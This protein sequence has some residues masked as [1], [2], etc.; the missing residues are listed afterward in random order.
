MSHSHENGGVSHSHDGPAFNAV[1]HGHSHEILGGPGSY[2][3]RE[4]PIVEGRDWHERAFTIGIGGY[5]NLIGPLCP[6][7]LCTQ[8][9]LR[10]THLT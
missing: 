6:S 9:W 7:D 1:E 10:L 5:G 4:M 3:G 2:L 8:K